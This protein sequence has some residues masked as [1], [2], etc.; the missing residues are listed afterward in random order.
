LTKNQSRIRIL[1][2]GRGAKVAYCTTPGFFVKVH[3]DWTYRCQ[4]T[5]L[6][7]HLLDPTE[8]LQVILN[9]RFNVS[10]NTLPKVTGRLSKV[11]LQY[12]DL[13]VVEDFANEF[14]RKL[15]NN[16]GEV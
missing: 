4:Q 12:P 3:G 8:V 1:R 6:G 5:H 13:S 9:G 14:R 2:G 7:R 16:D 10:L 11:E 15:V